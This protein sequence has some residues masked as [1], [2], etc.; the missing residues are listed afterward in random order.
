M[1]ISEHT[2]VELIKGQSATTQAILD[3]RN[4]MDKAIPYLV[5]Q[6]EKNSLSIQEVQKKVWYL[7]GAGTVIG[8]LL[9]KFG[10]HTLTLFG[11][12]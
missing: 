6:D 1:E 5:A 7:S 4:S 10:A 8:Y 9:S 12:K 11:G 2:I 3:L